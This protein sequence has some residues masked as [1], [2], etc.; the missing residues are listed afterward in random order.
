MNLTGEPGLYGVGEI[1][2]RG[3]TFDGVQIGRPA[4]GAL[5]DAGFR[6]LGDLP[7]DLDELLPIHA[8]GP[9]A[10][11]RLEAERARRRSPAP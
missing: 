10:L 3:T 4:T 11:R 6:S 9:G 8:V 5:L 1:Q 2:D 7:T